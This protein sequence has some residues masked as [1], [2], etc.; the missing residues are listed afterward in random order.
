MAKIEEQ[1]QLA[2]KRLSIQGKLL[3]GILIYLLY[4]T[5]IFI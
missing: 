5:A 4:R 2:L 3:R 1:L